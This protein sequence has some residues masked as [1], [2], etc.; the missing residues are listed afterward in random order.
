M[1]RLFFTVLMTL[2]F[3]LANSASSW[4]TEQTLSLSVFI[5][6]EY[7]VIGANGSFS[8]NFYYTTEQAPDGIHYNSLKKEN[9]DVFDEVVEYLKTIRQR[10]TRPDSN[11]ITLIIEPGDDALAFS[12]K[13]QSYEPLIL[14]LKKQDLRTFQLLRQRENFC[15]ASKKIPFEFKAQRC[16]SATEG[17]HRL[18]GGFLYTKKEPAGIAGGSSF[19]GVA[20]GY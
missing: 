10:I 16:G 15:K 13:M 3:V 8:P 9:I 7:I 1:K 11:D 5:T 18:A 12:Q 17:S 6:D 20:L 2:W 4:A 14:K 19:T